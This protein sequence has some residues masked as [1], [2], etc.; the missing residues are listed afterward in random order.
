MDWARMLA[1][2]TGTVDQELLLRYEYLVAENRILKAQLKTRLRLTDAERVTLA[3]IAHRLGRKALQDVANTAKPDTI[4]GW[5]RKL[6]ARKFDGSKSRRYPGRPRIDGEIEQ[7]VVRMAKEN[8]DWGYDRIVGAMANLGYTLSDQTVGNIL[9]RQGIPPAPER[10]HSTTWIDFIRAHMSVLAGTD[11]FSVE[12][13]TLRGLV[14]YYVLFFIHLESRRVEVA[15]ITPH[16]NEA[17]MK[18][19]ARNVT[20]DEWGFLDGCRYLI[21]DRDTKYCQSFRKII[22]SGDVKTLRLPARS[23]NL[24]AFSE[25]WVKSVKNECLSKLI[26]FG[27]TSLRRALREYLVH[28]H[29]E[30]NHQGK[31]NIL[32]F[33]TAGKAMNRIDGSVGCKERLGGL[34]KYYYREAA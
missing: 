12:V 9:Q 22:E 20:M 8:S 32:L 18:Q 11:F 28:Y 1:Y 17:W 21:H 7:L 10:Q 26:L 19:I 14:T 6:V 2:I 25:R 31:D 33:P 13:L 29:R 16:P 4:M 30:R 34:L 3:E 5:Y 24:N 27:E 23:P 15:G